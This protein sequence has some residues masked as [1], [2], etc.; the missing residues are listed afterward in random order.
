ML[1][2]SNTSTPIAREGWFVED[3]TPLPKSQSTPMAMDENWGQSTS[4]DTV[5]SD[6]GL[7]S[8]NP[9][10]NR[11]GIVDSINTD[12][13]RKVLDSQEGRG[14]KWMESRC[15][16]LPKPRKEKE[17]EIE[18]PSGFVTVKQKSLKT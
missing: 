11:I 17:W 10:L 18:L 12:R 6:V 9:I 3:D 16:R 7:C 2:S 4:L 1:V 5:S 15:L 8:S 13:K 14:S